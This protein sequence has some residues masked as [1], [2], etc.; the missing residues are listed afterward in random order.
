[1]I[2]FEKKFRLCANEGCSKNGDSGKNLKVET[3]HPHTTLHTTISKS[4]D[5]LHLLSGNLLCVWFCFQF[6]NFVIVMLS[7][8]SAVWKLCFTLSSAADTLG[9]LRGR[10]SKGQSPNSW[11][12]TSRLEGA[13]DSSRDQERHQRPTGATGWS[14]TSLWTITSSQVR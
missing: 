11:S 10:G 3:L 6:C 7:N 1:M 5:F 9:W 4:N 2:L 14:K 13:Q 8:Q 12:A